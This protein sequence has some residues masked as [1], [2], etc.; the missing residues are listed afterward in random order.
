MWRMCID[1]CTVNTITVTDHWR[2]SLI[3]D[4]L[5]SI[6][7]SCW[8]TQ[9]DLVAAYHQILI[10]TADRQRTAFATTFG[11][12]EWRVLPF[13][14]ANAPS[15]FLRMMKSILEPMKCKFM[16]MY[17]DN[18]M[19]HSRTLVDHVIHVRD[20]HTFPKEHGLKVKRAKCAWACQKF[21]FCGFDIDKDNIHAQE[22]KTR[23]V[24]DRP[25]P[26]NSHDVRGFLGLSSY[27][28]KFIRHYAHIAM[29]L[30]AFGTPS[31]GK[32]S[33][34]QRRGEPRKVKRTPFT[35]DSQC[36]HAFNTGKKHCAMFE[37]WHYRTPKPIIACMSMPDSMHWAQCSPTCKTMQRW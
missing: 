9:L 20:Q 13:G 27:Y 31:R 14:M 5:N 23:A 2:L 15:Q 18:K 22:H 30:Y 33:V 4:L 8:F 12:Y 36:Q 29:L 19:N 17:L 37:F 25:A 6:H 24:M 10:A 3:E 16:V 26:E 28:R 34:G 35:R 11:L 7:S 1:Y 21:N 32:G